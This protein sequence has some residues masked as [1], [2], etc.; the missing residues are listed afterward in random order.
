MGSRDLVV[1][2]IY[3]IHQV[4][5]AIAQ[6]LQEHMHL[7]QIG[8]THHKN[9]LQT[10]RSRTRPKQIYLETHGNSWYEYVLNRKREHETVHILAR[11]RD[12][13]NEGG[14]GGLTRRGGT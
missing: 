8:S 14:A 6:L 1:G 13:K 11:A 4:W 7:T 10:R 3:E 12:K 9:P 2:S 5:N